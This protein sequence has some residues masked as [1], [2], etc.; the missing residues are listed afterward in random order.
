MK[1]AF[2]N[3]SRVSSGRIDRTW[4][5]RE[6]TFPYSPDLVTSSALTKLVKGESCLG[7]EKYIHIYVYPHLLSAAG[8]ASASLANF[9]AVVASKT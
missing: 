7:D 6:A 1:P 5:E 8:I 2:G 9:T 3:A 4:S